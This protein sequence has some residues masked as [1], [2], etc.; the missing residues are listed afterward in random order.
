MYQANIP[1]RIY[2]MSFVAIDFETATTSG[3]ACQLGVIEVKDGEIINE[4][5]FLIRPPMNRYDDQCMNVHHITPDQT[6][7]AMTFE[8]LWPEIRPYFENR[9][10]V[11]HNASFD[12]SIL[13]KNVWHYGLECVKVQ[14]W[15][16]TCCDLG[17]ATLHSACRFFDIPFFNHHD[18]LAD[19]RASAMLY[20]K[21]VQ[22]AGQ[23]V[24]IP[25]IRESKF[26]SL[27]SDVKKQ[28]LEH[29]QNRNT[30]FYNKKVVI[31]G[32]FDSYPDRE[33]LAQML[34]EYGADINGSISKR[35]DLVLIGRGAG[36]KK[37][38]TIEKINGGGGNIH[39]IHEP[40]LLEI[41]ANIKCG[42]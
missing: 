35:T 15:I 2:P 31:T 6:E 25:K 29:C 41:L 16:C 22:M 7:E 3:M 4:V 13:M 36:P 1:D 26:H 32:V 12:S 8:E 27:S 9:V 19:A 37:L 17:K 39:C 24:D 21:Y 5:K 34:K 40:E 33:Q 20:L 28:D 14:E 11:A 23:T 18:A 10:V 30:I 42:E 38:Q